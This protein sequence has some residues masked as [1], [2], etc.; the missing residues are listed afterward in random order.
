MPGYFDLSKL[1]ALN[2]ALNALGVSMRQ[3]TP[4]A[5]AR[6]FARIEDAQRFQY[7]EFA[8]YGDLIDFMTVLLKPDLHAL[9]PQEINN[10]ITAAQDVIIA[11]KTT[12]RF[13]R[14]TGLSVWL[15]IDKQ[16]F[17]DHA[18]RY[19]H[20]RFSMNSQWGETLSAIVEA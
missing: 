6:V 7:D 17:K 18:Q 2:T 19:K 3:L 14:A 8:D 13:V 20:L 9:N 5:R 1:S 4:D 16:W 10:V 11:N 15:P 12:K